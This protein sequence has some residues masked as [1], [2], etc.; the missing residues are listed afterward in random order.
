[1]LKT[2]GTICMVLFAGS[3]A[4]FHGSYVVVLTGSKTRNDLINN[5]EDSW[6]TLDGCVAHIKN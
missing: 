5:V 6:S 2:H 3:G 1:M 4:R